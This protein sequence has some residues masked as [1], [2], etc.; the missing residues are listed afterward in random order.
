MDVGAGAEPPSVAE[1]GIWQETRTMNYHRPDG[2]ANQT[3]RGFI[4]LA[5]VFCRIAFVSVYRS[6]ASIDCSRP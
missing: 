1:V 4:G 5:D 2:A 6:S 3:P